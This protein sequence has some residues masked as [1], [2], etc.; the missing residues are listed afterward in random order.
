MIAS[1]QA[2]TEADVTELSGTQL[3]STVVP[4]LENEGLAVTVSLTGSP[5]LRQ[6]TTQSTEIDVERVVEDFRP[7]PFHDL[8][9]LVDFSL[10]CGVNGVSPHEQVPIGV[11]ACPVCGNELARP[12]FVLSGIGFRIVDCTTCGLGRLHP[13]PDA[14]LIRQF[15]PASY[16]GV[17]GAKFVPA[18]EVLVRLVG[19]RRV[20]ALSRGLPKGAK[21]LDVG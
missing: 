12:R 13:R 6:T 10:E 7:S 9:E 16:Y 21:I 8:G 5:P 4:E 1:S 20:R 11:D 3:R 19:A 14:A 2:Q 18:I 17:T 15:Y